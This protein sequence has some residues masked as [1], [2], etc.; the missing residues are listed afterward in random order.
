MCL[1]PVGSEKFY[2]VAREV[3]MCSVR[4]SGNN[5]Y[6]TIINRQKQSPVC[7]FF[8]MLRDFGHYNLYNRRLRLKNTN[9]M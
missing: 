1:F 3:A 9:R 6:D 8:Q 2:S 4:E 5:G 7:E